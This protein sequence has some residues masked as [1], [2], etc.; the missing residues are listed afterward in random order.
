[1]VIRSGYYLAIDIIRSNDN[2]NYDNHVAKIT[3]YHISRSTTLSAC[4]VRAQA[5]GSGSDKNVVLYQTTQIEPKTC[6]S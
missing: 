6:G 4:P 5:S 3:R 2:V 1:M